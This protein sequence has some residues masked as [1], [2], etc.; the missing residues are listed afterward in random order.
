MANRSTGLA[1]TGSRGAA[2]TLIYQLSGQALTIG[3][4]AVV[5][6]RLGPHPYG[7]LGFALLVGLPLAG[8]ADLGLGQ[9]LMRAPAQS[10]EM[11]DS[12]FWVTLAGSATAIAAAVP[13]SLL[14]AE[15]Y[16]VKGSGWIVAVGA[17][18]ILLAVPA[19]APRAALARTFNFGK[20]A[21]SDFLGQ[22]ASGAAML[23]LALGGAG[24]WAL[25]IGLGARSL[26]ALVG[27]AVF[28]RF[29]PRLTFRRSALE[30][31]WPFGLRA[32]NAFI[33]RAQHRRSA[34]R[35]IPGRDRP[36]PLPGGFRRCSPAI[37]L[38]RRRDRQRRL[39]DV[40]SDHR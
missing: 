16:G 27:A 39:A 36:W 5:A 25:V 6:R 14:L 19:A 3:A 24:A 30:T 31:L 18:G 32:A 9:A 40:R 8:I 29:V 20:L 33:H 12:A 7:L 4:T 34:R 38:P 35:A 22:V 28:A 23:G 37:H 1:A 11:L 2:K 26:V 17:A 10:R 15:H 21:A 13:L